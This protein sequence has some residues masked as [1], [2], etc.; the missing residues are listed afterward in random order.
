MLQHAAPLGQ[1][2]AAVQSKP[3][4]TS[5]ITPYCQK[6]PQ[7]EPQKNAGKTAK[8]ERALTPKLN[9][10]AGGDFFNWAQKTRG[11]AALVC[12]S[13]ERGSEFDGR[14]KIYLH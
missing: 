14:G 3:I 2:A 10:R 4:H 13:F 1:T 8:A 9:P 12:L 5:Q 11:N 6:P 7:L